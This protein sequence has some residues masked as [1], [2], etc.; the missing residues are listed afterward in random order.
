ML[1]HGISIAI[2]YI[3][4][5]FT[6]FC[7][8]SFVLTLYTIIYS[9]YILKFYVSKFK[10]TCSHMLGLNT[11]LTQLVQLFKRRTVVPFMLPP[12]HE[13][14]LSRHR[15]AKLRG[16]CVLL[17]AISLLSLAQLYSIIQD[18]SFAGTRDH[19]PRLRD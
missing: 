16:R 3:T 1:S 17:S 4:L 8:F 19:M 2:L 9:K 13:D 5:A 7:Q 14:K 11:Y 18:L 10:K 12:C 6:V 15:G